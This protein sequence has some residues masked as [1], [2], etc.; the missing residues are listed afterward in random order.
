MLEILLEQCRTAYAALT[1]G[2]DDKRFVAAKK[3][4]LKRYNYCCAVTGKALKVLDV[5]HLYSAKDY[6]QYVYTQKYLLPLDPIIHRAF[7][8]AMGGTKVP[9]TPTDFW[10]WWEENKH[11]YLKAKPKGWFIRLLSKIL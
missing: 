9:C 11:Q 3:I 4:C 8:K 2:K 5:H 6:P 7:H 10:D 1:K